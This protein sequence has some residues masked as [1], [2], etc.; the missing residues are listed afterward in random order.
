[1]SWSTKTLLQKPIY[2]SLFLAKVLLIVDKNLKAWLV[3]V[4]GLVVDAWAL[5]RPLQEEAFRRGL[6]PYMPDENK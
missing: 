4:D 5:P 2:V 3:S 6:I 1:L